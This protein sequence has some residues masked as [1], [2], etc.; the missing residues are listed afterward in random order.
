MSEMEKEKIELQFNRL[1]LVGNGF[2]LAL[3]LKTSYNDFLL[4]LQKKYLLLTL[5]E[6]PVYTHDGRNFN[7]GYL[8]NETFE[9]GIKHYFSNVSYEIEIEKLDTLVALEKFQNACKIEINVKSNLLKL[10]IKQNNQLGWVDIESLFYKE[11]KK[12]FGKNIED[13]I[14]V[15]NELNFLSNELEMYL[16]ENHIA[17]PGWREFSGAVNNQLSRE[18]EKNELEDEH[19]LGNNKIPDILYFLNFNYTKALFDMTRNIESWRPEKDIISIWNPIHGQLQN[20]KAPIIFGFGDETDKDYEKIEDLN[21]NS[22]FEHIKS[23]KYSQT[24]N[25]QNL[26]KFLDSTYYQVCIYGHSCGLSARTMLKEIFQHDNCKSIKIF[27]H[28]RHNGSDDFL[29]KT[30]EI[31]RHFTN[32]A[33]MRRKVV[34]KENSQA[35]PQNNL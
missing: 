3:G 4:W 6:K 19:L 16:S 34:N 10:I 9:I 27:Y 14:K 33:S 5:E 28:K 31:S 30:M 25:Y 26:I 23:F 1:V 32:K 13:V 8:N 17:P 29:E 7:V 12:C 11:L 15:N 21:N 22:F 2:D 20:P 35:M 18:I 24:S